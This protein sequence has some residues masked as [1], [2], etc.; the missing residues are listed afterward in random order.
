VT[1]SKNTTTG[2]N[3][4]PRPVR[5]PRGSV[6]R[7]HLENILLTAI[8]VGSLALIT[9]VAIWVV[10][11]DMPQ[12][13]PASPPAQTPSVTDWIS[14]V[15][16]AI[17]ALGTAGALWLGAITFRRQVRDQHRAQ[18]AGTAVI[19]DANA[20]DNTAVISVVNGTHLPIYGVKLMAYDQ[21]FEEIIDEYRDVLL[22]DTPWDESVA[23]SVVKNANIE[24]TDSAGT[25][26]L[27]WSTARG[28]AEKKGDVFTL[29]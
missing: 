20:D 26:W 1:K 25:T 17:G 22:P 19:V 27:R 15:G 12:Q 2:R 24:F 5:H 6:P 11:V 18:A 7:R 10:N 13:A 8:L 9:F 29:D 3:I 16:G 28:L 4:P 23:T 14:A 21:D